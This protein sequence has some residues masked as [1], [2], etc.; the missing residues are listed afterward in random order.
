MTVRIFIE[1][2]YSRSRVDGAKNQQKE[3]ENI[4]Y[5]KKNNIGTIVRFHTLTNRDW[6]IALKHFQS[7]SIFF[8]LSQFFSIG[9]S[10]A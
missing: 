9:L 6:K 7:F 1:R 5:S 10:A 8:N 2:Y 4:D 3:E